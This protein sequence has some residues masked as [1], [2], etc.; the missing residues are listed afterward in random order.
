MIFQTDLVWYSAF[1]AALADLRKNLFVIEDA[2][3][4]LRTDPFLRK[5][6]GE[7]EVERLKA[8]LSKEIN[9]FVQHRTPDLA[10][11]PAIVIRCGSAEEDA[12]K[13]ALGDSFQQERVD[14]TTLG[15]AY[16]E[17][18]VLIGPITPES[19]D[20]LTGTIT[21][22]DN[23]DLSAS[24]IFDTHYIYDV[25]NQKYYGIQLVLDSSN[26]LIEPNSKPNLTNMLIKRSKDSFGHVRRSVWFWET[27]SI[28]LMS[29]DANE[30]IYLYTIVMLILIRYKKQLLDARNFAAMTVSYSEIYR[31]SA[32]DDPNNVYGR[33]L[34]IRGRVE[35]N[36]IESTGP[37]IGGVNMDLEIAGMTSPPAVLAS[38]VDPLWV[39]QGDVAQS[40]ED[41]DE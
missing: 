1:T 20:P 25:V 34:T 41:D 19:Y 2:Y 29:T 6:Y 3:S 28:D 8:F 40:T 16:S 30:L 31:V 23:V 12:H 18:S 22:G 17:S 39:G 15:G 33:T 36:A 32:E 37:L 24:N 5:L 14:P 35:N 21:F 13:D 10:K 7:K 26:L 38:E 4:Q 11:F 27:D 9:I